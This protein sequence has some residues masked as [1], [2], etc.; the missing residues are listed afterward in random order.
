MPH[1]DY[2]VVMGIDDDG[3]DMPPINFEDRG[4]AAAYCYHEKIPHFYE[5]NSANPMEPVNLW[6]LTKGR[7]SQRYGLKSRRWRDVL[8][9]HDGT[10]H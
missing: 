10:M 8:Q 4:Q 2:Y 7:N 3:N 1:D 6:E 9:E 5:V